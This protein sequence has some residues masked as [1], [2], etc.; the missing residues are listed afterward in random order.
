MV[1]VYRKDNGEKVQVPD[2]WVGHP[3]LG[4]PFRKTPPQPATV[5]KTT[6]TETTPA[7]GDNQKKE[8]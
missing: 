5:N 3:R 4:K 8:H 7:T 2:H 1:T 6:T